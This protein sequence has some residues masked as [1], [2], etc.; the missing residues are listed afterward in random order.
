ML[1]TH[2][3]IDESTDPQE[4]LFHNVSQKKS[5]ADSL[6]QSTSLF[7]NTPYSFCAELSQD[8]DELRD[9]LMDFLRVVE[10]QDETSSEMSSSNSGNLK[11]QSI[12]EADAKEFIIRYVCDAPFIK[13]F[14]I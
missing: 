14:F 1:L 4:H 12:A 7:T 5:I 11:K 10:Q 2:Y 3:D 6:I 8:E 9:K 13:V